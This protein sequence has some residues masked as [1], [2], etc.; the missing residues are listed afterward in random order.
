[1]LS[2]GGPHAGAPLQATG[3]RSR[4]GRRAGET[5]WETLPSSSDLTLSA[6]ASRARSRLLPPRRPPRGSLHRSSCVWRCAWLGVQTG[7]RRALRTLGGSLAGALLVVPIERLEVNDTGS[8]AEACARHHIYE[9]VPHRQHGH[10]LAGH[11]IAGE[12]NRGLGV[13]RSVIGDQ[14]HA[15]GLSSCARLRDRKLPE[16]G[17]SDRED[18]SARRDPLLNNESVA[19]QRGSTAA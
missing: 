10:R 2:A 15:R 9:R 14:D 1:M 12:I 5:A 17:A 11:Q 6:H 13:L 8:N 3:R 16:P 18:A 4:A 19:R 7:A